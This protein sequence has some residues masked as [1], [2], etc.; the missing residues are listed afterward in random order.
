M[1]QTG[2]SA[3]EIDCFCDQMLSAAGCRKHT[4][5][6]VNRYYR[7]PEWSRWYQCMMEFTVDMYGFGERNADGVL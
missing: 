3:E 1:A 4:G 5:N 7:T 6:R 2:G